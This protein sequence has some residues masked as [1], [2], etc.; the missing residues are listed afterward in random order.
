MKFQRSRGGVGVGEQTMEVNVVLVVMLAL[1][2][3]A[4]HRVSSELQRRLMVN[5]T[6]VRNAAALGARKFFPTKKEKY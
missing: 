2:M 1:L 3:C 5:M 4:P 6:V